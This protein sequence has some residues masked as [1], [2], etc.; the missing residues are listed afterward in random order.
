[1]KRLLLA[2]ALLGSASFVGA[3]PALAFDVSID[4]TLCPIDIIGEA[5]LDSWAD[6]LVASKGQL[7]D[8]QEDRLVESKAVCA[9]NLGWSEKDTI[10]A[11]EFNLSVIA[12]TAIGDSLKADGIDVISYEVVLEN[13]SAADL[14][15]V[16]EDPDNSIVLKEFT[17][18]MLT[19]L[20]DKLT[21]EIT[22][23]LATYIAFMAQAQ[24]SAMKMSGL[25]E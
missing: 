18:K 3:A 12:S 7:S 13:R 5:E 1:M 17:D 4:D 16:L 24:L 23:D 10:S 19:D 20:G 11:L 15:Q 6:T 21:D 9:Q 25:A 14:R 2:A 8:A 22:A